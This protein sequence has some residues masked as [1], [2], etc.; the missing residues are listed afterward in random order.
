MA[1][2]GL[3]QLAW[4]LGCFHMTGEVVI[5]ADLAVNQFAMVVV[6]GQRG[7]HIRQGNGG[8]AEGD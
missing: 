7:M 4:L 3:T 5:L 6:V 8:D 2:L 1:S